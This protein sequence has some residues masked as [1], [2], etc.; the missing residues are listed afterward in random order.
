MKKILLVED[1]VLI[2]LNQMNVLKENGFD[3]SHAKS[4]KEAIEK[5]WFCDLVLM[6]LDL[7]RGMDGS[8]AAKEILKNRE[9]PIIFLTSHTDKETIDR[10]QGISNYGYVLKNSGRF[11]L[12]ESIRMAFE[13]YDAYKTA[14]TNEE[15]YKNIFESAP[16][17]IFKTTSDG[18]ILKTNKKF[19]K[20][21][22]YSDIDEIINIENF[23]LN[24][25]Y[26]NIED[27]SRLI[28]ELEKHGVVENFEFKSVTK[29]GEKKWI[30]LNAIKSEEFDD[31]FVLD[32]F[33]IDIDDK[34]SANDEI[35]LAE[36][37]FRY[38]FNEM[39]E[40]VAI[41]KPINDGED[42]VFVD[43]N[44]AGEKLSDIKKENVV[45]KRV[46]EVFP[47]IKDEG[48]NLFSTFQKANN[49]RETQHHPL[50][51]YDDERIT[52][53]VENTVYKLNSGEIV[54]LYLDTTKQKVAQEELIRSERNLRTILE[55]IGD[56]VI[57]TDVNKNI[58]SINPVAEQLIGFS[59]EECLGRKMDEV[60]NIVSSKTGEV[61]SNP[62]NDAIKT[63]E[64]QY[65]SN[66]IKLVSKCGKEY[67]ISD[68]A[69]PIF[70]GEEI[71]GAVLVFRDITEEYLKNE[72]IKRSEKNLKKLA[73]EKENLMKELN[74]RVKNNLSIIKS[75]VQIKNLE[76][77]ED[78]T[79]IISQ[80][81]SI[82]VLHE[83]LY[84]NN[85]G[86][87]LSFSDYIKSLLTNIFSMIPN[88]HVDLQIN[89]D[90]SLNFDNKRTLNLGLI[91]N[92]LATNAIKYGFNFDDKDQ[93][94]NISMSESEY[95][96]TLE[97]SNSGNKIPD[98]FDIEKSC[99][100]GM[101]LIKTMIN[102][103]GGDIK[104]EK[105]NFTKFIL[106]FR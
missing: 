64:I 55:S 31:Y 22:G 102:D 29:S 9:I 40:G 92:E 106:T 2:A 1:E 86:D 27:R 70:N 45:G 95:H 15:N 72:E 105:D 46:T 19:A 33:Y 36:S 73:E 61:V 17:G 53:Y 13:L 41:Y 82:I 24:S 65:L 35:K 25:L 96:Y 97:V 43:I 4:G 26:D 84:V 59:E 42:F 90:S 50:L 93:F 69:A 47:G 101:S 32:G 34:K 85:S 52:Q 103:M 99:N 8:Q 91:L 5:S 89:I 71:T 16:I 74:H 88:K 62:V 10:V 68:S 3:V 77:S 78:L 39:H 63:G 79:D 38:L 18:R 76:I 20:I 37:R 104:I 66:H 56:G 58:K 6:D 51:Q 44:E 98:D 49:T 28:S 23:L 87:N 80:I 83:K 54:A 14:K 21:L 60:F 75:Y 12:M 30:S 57:S 67:H 94:F 11:V 7:G 100:T 81:Q 48:F